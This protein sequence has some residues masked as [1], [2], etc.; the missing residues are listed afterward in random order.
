MWC[1]YFFQAAL[2]DVRL[3][4]M[5]S[6]FIPFR[7]S[8]FFSYGVYGPNAALSCRGAQGKKGENRE[9]L[10]TGAEEDDKEERRWRK[11]NVIASCTDD[12]MGKGRGIRDM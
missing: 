11:I 8:F 1:F 12:V 5:S 7:G 4:F 9:E 3:P 2:Y 10:E 6:D